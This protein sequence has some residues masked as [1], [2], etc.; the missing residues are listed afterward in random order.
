MRFRNC[1]ESRRDSVN[2]RI[3]ALPPNNMNPPICGAVTNYYRCPRTENTDVAHGYQPN[4]GTC[5][6]P[7]I[8]EMGCA[9][10]E[11]NENV[12]VTILF[13]SSEKFL[14]NEGS[15]A[16]CPCTERPVQP[17]DMRSISAANISQS[18]INEMVVPKPSLQAVG[19]ADI[20]TQC[21][22]NI[23]MIVQPSTKCV[24]N[25]FRKTTS[26]C[27][28]NSKPISTKK[29]TV[30][31]KDIHKD[32]TSL[33]CNCR[34]RERLAENESI[35]N[36]K[37]PICLK[38]THSKYSKGMIPCAKRCKNFEKES[39]PVNQTLCM[40]A[41]VVK[42]SLKSKNSKERKVKLSNQVAC[43]NDKKIPVKE[44]PHKNKAECLMD[45]LKNKNID[46]KELSKQSCETI[47]DFIKKN[48]PLRNSLE[49]AFSLTC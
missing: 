40:Q 21:K 9:A 14:N 44:S 43:A 7:K 42:S 15:I 4:I 36:N 25:E 22:E 6:I 32:N 45:T 23:Y 26:L 34:N 38:D 13:D 2:Y 3:N 8:Q 27:L 33:G 20:N 35:A 10:T 12:E 39:M 28:E 5:N 30:Q 41:D 24:K 18:Y 19:I 48:V 49:V 29:S 31:T 47:L 37:K 46:L 11:D 17:S 1:Y 16:M